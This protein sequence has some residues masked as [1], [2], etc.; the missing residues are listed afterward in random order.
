MAK[1][2]AIPEENMP[3]LEKK[4]TRIRNKC[5]K[6][7]CAF[8]Y[9]KVGEHMGERKVSWQEVDDR[10]VIVTR[11]TIIPVKYIDIEVEGKAEVN[12]WKFVASLEHTSEGNIIYSIGDLEIPHRYYDCEPYC[13]HCK[14]HRARKDSFIIYKDETQEFKQVGKNCLRDFTFGMSAEAVAQYEQAF[15]EAEEASESFS[16]GRFVPYIKTIDYASYVAETIRIFGYV[17]RDNYAGTPGTADIAYDFYQYDHDL[18]RI[19][20][21]REHIGTKYDEAKARGWDTS[22]T[23]SRA[24]AETVMAWILNNDRDDN[25]FHNLKVACAGEYIVC[26]DEGLVASAFPAYNRQ[27]EW[28]AEKRDRELKAKDEAARSTW[29]GNVGD[30]VTFKLA[31]YSVIT[32]WE[33]MYGTTYV[34]KMKDDNGLTYT[35]K[36][37]NHVGEWCIGK[38]YKATIKEL[39]E[40]RGVKQTEITRAKIA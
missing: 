10:G 25:Y 2:F 9:R 12:G 6:Y 7:D 33:T 29:A 39:K 17:K 23:D 1:Q 27:L 5:A 4:L 8:D 20:E 21:V 13:E 22:L 26:R 18:I 14:V 30:R 38:T 19:P 35:W 16:W 37:S 28:D 36:T 32:S 24:L 11:S 40:F 15:K 3:S 34:Y 31:D